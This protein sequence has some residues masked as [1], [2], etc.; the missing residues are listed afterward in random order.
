MIESLFSSMKSEEPSPPPVE[1]SQ[2]GV[3]T[4]EK[5]LDELSKSSREQWTSKRAK[6]WLL[7]NM[8]DLVR[9]GK[10][11]QAFD[12]YLKL[13]QKEGRYP[14]KKEPEDWTKLFD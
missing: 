6:K 11:N 3:A 2:D 14:D 8:V 13:C 12:R 9:K 4:P 5:M 7:E 1:T 10:W